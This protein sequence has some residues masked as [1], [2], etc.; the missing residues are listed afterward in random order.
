VSVDVLTGWFANASAEPSRPAVKDHSRQLDG[1]E[2]IEQVE[3]L[4]AGL[5][6]R[7]I[8]P[9]DR[10]A[11]QLPNSVDFV[12]AAL[13]CLW[14]GAMFIPLAATDP[15]ARV[16]AIVA[17]CQP[18]LILTN[19]DVSEPH[20]QA[21][22]LDLVAVAGASPPSR[23]EAGELAAY[24]I[25][26]SGTTGAPKGVVIGRRAFAAGVWAVINALRLDRQTRTLCVSPVHFDGS[27]ATIFPTLV[28][29]GS[30]VMPPRES[31]LFARFFVR[32]VAQEQITYTGFSSSYLR[33]LLADPKRE[34]LADTPLQIIALGGEACSGPDVAELWTYAP[35]IRV[36]NRY[37]P[38]ETT[39][40]VTHFEVTQAVLDRGG[41]V[42]IGRPH[43]SV[44]FHLVDQDDN[45]VNDSGEVYIGGMQLMTGYWSAPQ[46]TESVLR[47]D[48]VPG[49]TVYRTGDLVVRD[50]SGDYV[51][52]DRADRVVKRHAVRISLVELGDVLRGIPG[53]TAA[54]CVAFDNAGQLGIAGFVVTAAPQHP[55][56]LRQAASKLLPQ[57]MLPDVIEVVDA[58][59]LTSSSKADER[60]LL[61]EAGLRQLSAS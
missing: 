10:V 12:V 11:L 53:V 3:L 42:P 23:V 34:R 19:A 13:A 29:G 2:L 24:A 4:A 14:V 45:H 15:S 60:R 33:L 41:A 56:E 46:L 48:V 59:P 16:A 32:A 9:A 6:A 55:L 25:Y 49:E 40:A 5:A 57:S 17:D 20:P 39:I 21:M 47:T 50:Q 36:F 22:H 1:G 51:Y 54:L 8:G 30:L 43:D 18:D 7:G 38:T 58:F 27:F 26:T 31:L 28:A 37:G 61:S 52:V 35:Q 44:T